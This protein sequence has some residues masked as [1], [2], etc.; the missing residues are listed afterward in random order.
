VSVPAGVE[1]VSL[2]PTLR[3]QP[4]SFRARQFLAY[5]EAHYQRALRGPRYKLIEYA[6]DGNR[7]TELFDLVSDPWEMNNLAGRP[8][9]AA[10]LADTRQLLREAQA[11]YHDP[12]PPV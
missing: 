5:G 7:I 6:F 11:R 1:S 12:Q 8:G 9:Q 2:A 4:Q 3:G 10:R